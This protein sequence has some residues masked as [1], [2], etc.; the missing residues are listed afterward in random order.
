MSSRFRSGLRIALG[1]LAVMAVDGALAS[2]AS[3]QQA[4]TRTPRVIE[5]DGEEVEGR[6]QGPGTF[7]VVSRS[8]QEF[9]T[10]LPRPS[11]VPR[12]IE[13]VERRPF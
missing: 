1:A 3:A 8:E 2:E 6:A 5:L 13:S 4:A 9:I 11:F 10:P 12:I 7:Y